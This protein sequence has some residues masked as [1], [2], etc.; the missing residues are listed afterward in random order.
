MTSLTRQ[1]WLILLLPFLALPIFPSDA[2]GQQAAPVVESQVPLSSDVGIVEISP[3]VRSRLGL[4]P[5]VQGFSAAR[6]LL[7]TNGATILE[8]ESR[9]GGQLRRERSVL[10][11]TELEEFRTLIGTRLTAAGGSATLVRDG[12]G[13]LVLTQTLLG[14]GFYGWAV[15][16]I[17]DLDEAQSVV[18]AYLLT[19][20]ASF[21][22]PYRLTRNRSVSRAHSDLTFYGS[23]RGILTGA[24]VADALLSDDSTNEGRKRL[25]GTL[26][27]SVAGSILGFT[28]VDLFE[29]TEGRA[30]LWGAMGDFGFAGGAALAHLAGPY[31][32]E[33]V[34][35]QDGEFSYTDSRLKNP[36]AGHL[37]TVAGGVAGLLASSRIGGPSFTEGNVGGIRSA[38]IL[39]A[40]IGL[41]LAQ[42]LGMETEREEG[43]VVII[44]DNTRVL[45]AGGLLGGIAGIYLGDRLLEEKRFTVGEGLLINAGHLAGGVTAL[46]LTYLI[47]ENIDDNPLLY[48]STST[49]GSFLGAWI[50][51]R[52]LGDGSEGFAALGSGGLHDEREGRGGVTIAL[53][54]ENL[55]LGSMSRSERSILPLLKIR[56]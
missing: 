14:L 35:I 50:V 27:G 37:M 4:F 43:D 1:L 41:T 19:A 47:Q 40:Q 3:A 28:A 7:Q 30:S 13:R 34:T 6:L 45:A 36:A 31:D 42:A 12:R 15:P 8:V 21:Y 39:G 10:T 51:Y 53:H 24:L 11:P 9:V 55:I 22:I 33:Y 32:H 52:S 56:F 16:V 44:E 20:G 54:P 5:E 23:T 26:I 46:G 18:G 48:L 2:S 38:G 17:L 29:P 49:A 25:T